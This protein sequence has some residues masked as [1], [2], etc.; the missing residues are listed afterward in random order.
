MDIDRS[1]FKNENK[2]L[3]KHYEEQA[4]F[5][6]I[7]L[8]IKQS[9]SY[10]ELRD[11]PVSKLYG[12]EALKYELNGYYGFNLCVNGGVIRLIC[13]IDKERKIVKLIYISLNHYEDFK[14][15]IKINK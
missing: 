12:F 4:T 9:K 5:E 10:E 6:K 3:K 2:K 13:K 15:K 14:L 8:H 11:N 7:L 1:D